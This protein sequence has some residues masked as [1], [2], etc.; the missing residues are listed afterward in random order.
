MNDRI[1][2]F[3]WLVTLAAFVAIS[4]T[5]AR[6]AAQEGENVLAAAGDISPDPCVKPFLSHPAADASCWP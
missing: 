5:P 1:R 3:V 6:A 2:A 4:L